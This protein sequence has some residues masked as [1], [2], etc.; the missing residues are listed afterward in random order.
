MKYEKSCGA[1]IY[2]EV[3]NKRLFLIIHMNQGHWSF[4][5]GHVEQGETEEQTAKRE[6]YE[7]TGI[8]YD[9]LIGFRFVTQY[10][11]YPNTMKDVVFFLGITEQSEIVVQKEELQEA[12]F[13]SQS[14]AISLLTFENDKQAFMKAVAFLDRS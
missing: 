3:N 14:E 13:V 12:R 11:P 4:P 2:T 5:K 9:E 6:V 7:E 10:S 1:I 8:Q